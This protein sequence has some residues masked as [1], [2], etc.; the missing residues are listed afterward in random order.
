MNKKGLLG[1][2][3]LI[4]IIL[5]LIIIGIIAFTVWQA[6]SL[7][8]TIQIEG[9]SIKDNLQLVLNGDCSKRANVQQSLDNLNE[10]TSNSCKNPVLNYVASKITQLPANCQT[11]PELETQMRSILALTENNC[12]NQTISS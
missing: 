5:I 3:F 9:N 8:K 7:V 6:Y 4:I 12:N 1:K 11:Y 2:I 10:K